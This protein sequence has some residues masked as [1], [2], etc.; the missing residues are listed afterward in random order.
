M[1]LLL[2][3]LQLPCLEEPLFKQL[4]RIPPFTREGHKTG[5]TFGMNFE[6]VRKLGGWDDYWHLIHLTSNLRDTTASFFRS[7]S[8]DVGNV[9]LVAAM[10]RR[11]N[12]TL[13]LCRF[14]FS[15]TGNS[16][17]RKQLSSLYKNCRNC[18]VRFMPEPHAKAHKLRKLDRPSSLTNSS[19]NFSLS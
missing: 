18:S 15:T 3:H 19:L 1:D 7:C 13:L 16:E 14:S 12:L 6:N 4:P 11:F 8:V 10:K 2:Q 9:S 5:E 17:R